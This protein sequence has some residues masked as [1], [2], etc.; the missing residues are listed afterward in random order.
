MLSKA[1]LLYAL[2][3]EAADVRHSLKVAHGLS[4]TSGRLAAMMEEFA[5]L[6]STRS[7]GVADELTIIRNE[8]SGSDPNT[9]LKA[10]DHAHDA[11]QETLNS[12]NS[13]YQQKNSNAKLKLQNILQVTKLALKE[14][15]TLEQT[16]LYLD[17]NAQELDT[18]TKLCGAVA[19]GTVV[20]KYTSGSYAVFNAS[21][22]TAYTCDAA[23]DEG[24]SSCDLIP[25][26]NQVEER[27]AALKAEVRQKK[28]EYDV[29]AKL[30]ADRTE[31][32][33]N[34]ALSVDRNSDYTAGLV[35]LRGEIE[36]ACVAHATYE[37]FLQN[38][39]DVGNVDSQSD[40]KREYRSGKLIVCLIDAFVADSTGFDTTDG[41]T[42]KTTTC[43]EDTDGTIAAGIAALNLN[44]PLDTGY[45]FHCRDTES[46]VLSLDT[47]D[48]VLPS[49]FLGS[50]AHVVELD[51]YSGEQNIDLTY[52]DAGKPQFAINGVAVVAQ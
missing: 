52:D 33:E 9:I 43:E 51:S 39:N 6:T 45:N 48:L 17:S 27:L 10:I 8:I 29:A 14:A 30:C 46:I 16:S 37:Q 36:T 25:Y 3:S 12:A 21:A 13:E 24:D 32:D 15:I 26:K 28:I 11:T 34:H 50:T 7:P 31:F 49:Q 4:R 20:S 47:D 18:V 5:L 23:V 40:R 22:P 42:T 2:H 44:V 35:E 1:V 19:P 41:L 38:T